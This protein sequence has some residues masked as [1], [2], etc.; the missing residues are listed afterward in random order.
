MNL[1]FG[2]IQWFFSYLPSHEWIHKSA[3]I[4]QLITTLS[5][6]VY[7]VRISWTYWRTKK[8][9]SPVPC[10]QGLIPNGLTVLQSPGTCAVDFGMPSGLFSCEWHSESH[11]SSTQEYRRSKRMHVVIDVSIENRSKKTVFPLSRVTMHDTWH[12]WHPWHPCHLAPTSTS[13][14]SSTSSPHWRRPGFAQPFGLSL[15][16]PHGWSISD[17]WGFVVWKWAAYYDGILGIFWSQGGRSNHFGMSW[18]I[19]FD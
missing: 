10:L 19:T 6:I 7:I 11:V 18:S 17:P 15:Q 9:C 8:T 16:L 2:R 13:S 4:Q 12:P 14:T 3:H 5:S 1:W